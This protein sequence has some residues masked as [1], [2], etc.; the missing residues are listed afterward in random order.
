MVTQQIPLLFSVS[1]EVPEHPVISPRSG[2]IF[3][4]RL[5]EK[6]IKDHGQ[7]PITG[8]SLEVEMLLDVKG[9]QPF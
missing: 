9:R 2:H 6:Y 8:E 4:R 3:E 7:D 1:N 5:I